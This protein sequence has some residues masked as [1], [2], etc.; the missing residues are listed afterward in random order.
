MQGTVKEELAQS[1]KGRDFLMLVD[2]KPEEIR[3]LIDLAIDLKKKKKQ[4]KPMM[5]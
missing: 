1:L 5:C 4:A 2:F 3:Y